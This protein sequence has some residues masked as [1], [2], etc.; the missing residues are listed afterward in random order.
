MNGSVRVSAGRPSANRIQ[1]SANGSPDGLPEIQPG[2]DSARYSNRRAIEMPEIPLIRSHSS[3]AGSLGAAAPMY[4][5]VTS[6]RSANAAVIR[7]TSLPACRRYAWQKDVV[8]P[9]RINSVVTTAG[10]A[11]PGRR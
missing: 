10:P 11:L 6:A 2:T 4:R 1:N 3:G 9:A 7:S 5:G 8:R